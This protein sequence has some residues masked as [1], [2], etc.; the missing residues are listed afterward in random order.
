[1]LVNILGSFALGFFVYEAQ[2]TGLVD[3]TSRIVF[4][5]GFLSSLTTYST[6]AIQT[7]ITAGPAE[8]LVLVAIVLGNYGLG[9]AGVLAS[10]TLARRVTGGSTA[11]AENGGETA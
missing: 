10:R 3:R 8:P 4:T 6:F 1:M 9:F 7:G 5:T 11:T 2:Y